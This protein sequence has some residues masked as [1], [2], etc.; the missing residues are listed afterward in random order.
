[1]IFPPQKYSSGRMRACARR[2]E[3]SDENFQQYR[4]KS[5]DCNKFSQY[6]PHFRRVTMCNETDTHTSDTNGISA[7]WKRDKKE[8]LANLL[9]RQ[10]EY[11]FLAI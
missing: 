11:N 2:Y 6:L 8:K 5:D 10:L 4:I 3:K 7:Y 9:H 1:M